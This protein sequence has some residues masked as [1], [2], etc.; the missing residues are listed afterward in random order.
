M[1]RRGRDGAKVLRRPKG[2]WVRFRPSG[3]TGAREI[4]A[5]KRPFATC[6]KLIGEWIL[7]CAR[8]PMEPSNS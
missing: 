5:L 1:S 8:S 3:A 2:K 6:G 4:G 7:D